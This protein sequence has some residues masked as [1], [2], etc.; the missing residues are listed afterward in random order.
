MSEGKK[1]SERG[2]RRAK[3]EGERGGA[4]LRVVIPWFTDFHATVRCT[5]S[6]AL[7]FEMRN[8]DTSLTTEFCFHMP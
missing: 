8:I 1:T 3:A 5:K 6:R 2:G 4:G 7:R